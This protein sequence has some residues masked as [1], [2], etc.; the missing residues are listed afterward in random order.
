MGWKQHAGINSIISYLFP[1]PGCWCCYFSGA[2]SREQPKHSP[3]PAAPSH[4]S[5]AAI[6]A[7][8]R[9]AP[10]VPGDTAV[11]GAITA[12]EQSSALPPE[13]LCRALLTTA[14]LPSP[15]GKSASSHPAV[16]RCAR[17]WWHSR[18][19]ELL[20]CPASQDSKIP[21]LGTHSHS[22]RCAHLSRKI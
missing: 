7:V 10:S 3:F 18:D 13:Q 14:P 17:V 2:G 9:K 21:P 15:R 22:I 16:P 19:K 4:G 12:D 1:Q 11:P 8:P 20:T 5:S 6:W